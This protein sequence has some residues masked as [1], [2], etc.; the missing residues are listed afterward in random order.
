MG[1]V[2]RFTAL[3]PETIAAVRADRRRQFFITEQGLCD[4][5]APAAP[6][7]NP[8]RD[9]FWK[10]LLRRFVPPP[11]PDF[12]PAEPVFAFDPDSGEGEMEDTDKAWHGLHF[13]L[14]GT[15]EGG[16]FPLGFM[17]VGGYP[18]TRH[19]GYQAGRVF[20]SGETE[21]ILAALAEVGEA[22]VR[23]GFDPGRMEAAAIYPEGLW[24]DPEAVDYLVDAFRRVIAFFERCSARGHG[25]AVEL[26]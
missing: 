13:C 3:K 23:A 22:G 26:T 20:D 25:F 18:L 11:M 24:H 2:I 1:L 19:T 12:A 9:T 15:A 17:V 21:A 10:A 6:P 7:A 8:G 4:D 16:A 5:G 14:T